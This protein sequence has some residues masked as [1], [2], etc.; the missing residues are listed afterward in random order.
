MS[1]K[2][3]IEEVA[4]FLATYGL[5]LDRYNNAKSIVCHDEEGYKY[6]TARANLIKTNKKPHILR[7]NPFAKDNIINY[8]ARNTPHIHIQ[9]FDYIDCRHAVPFICDHHKEMGVQRRIIYEVVRGDN[10]V[11]CARERAI[12]S[13]RIKP[14]TLKKACD[15]RGLMFVERTIVPKD[16]TSKIRVAVAFICEK[17]KQYGVQISDWQHFK[18]SKYGCS[19]CAG[20]HI[21]NDEFAKRIHELSPNVIIHSDYTGDE[22]VIKCEC[23]VCGYHWETSARSLKNGS[24]C[25]TCGLINSQAARLKTNEQFLTELEEANADIEAMEPYMGYHTFMRFRCKIDNCEWVT[26]PASILGKK[27]SCPSCRTYSNET[28]LKNILTEYGF[29]V[30]CQYRYDDCRD[31]HPMPFDL[32]LPDYN[33]LIEYDGEGHYFPIQFRKGK[34]TAEAMLERTKRHDAM[35]TAYCEQHGIPL[36][37]VPYYERNNMEDFILTKLKELGIHTLPNSVT[38]HEAVETAG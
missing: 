18:Y 1:K 7:G 14:E 31:I 38:L 9:N 33:V 20:K 2:I 10:C 25:H 23:A 24:G 6:E 5:I 3:V 17:H 12:D 27:S 32:Y 15:E 19:Y 13:I 16:R 11:Y 28:K 36:I 22:G 29:T 8:C 26:T 4:E 34:D 30:W 35:K 37:R 21:T